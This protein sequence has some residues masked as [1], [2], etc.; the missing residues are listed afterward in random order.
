MQSY[1]W[2]TVQNKH[3]FISICAFPMKPTI[4]LHYSTQPPCFWG[5][6]GAGGGA[7]VCVLGGYVG[8]MTTTG[9][10]L[11]SYRPLTL[12]SWMKIKLFLLSGGRKH[13]YR[14]KRSM[15]AV[16]ESEAPR[17]YAAAYGTPQSFYCVACGASSRNR[18]MG[19]FYI[20]L[21][22]SSRYIFKNKTLPENGSSKN[23][24]L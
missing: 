23:D 20:G 7:C 15:S 16:N 5:K 13:E 4:Y 22:V 2:R 18:N 6:G 12:M 19:E 9:Y 17:A 8:V 21:S 1:S 14:L 10:T 24:F 11:I 3:I